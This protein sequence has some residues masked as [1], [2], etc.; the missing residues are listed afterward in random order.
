MGDDRV[1]L[2]LARAEIAYDVLDL[3]CVLV[4]NGPKIVN[5]LP[6]GVDVGLS[7]LQKATFHAGIAGIGISEKPAVDE[8][9]E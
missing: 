3:C 6:P 2:T 5:Q 1:I 9:G 7:S 8:R 4:A